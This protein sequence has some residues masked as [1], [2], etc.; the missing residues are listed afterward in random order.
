MERKEI[1]MCLS[2]RS[3][4]AVWLEGRSPCEFPPV[5]APLDPATIPPK[6]HPPIP[7]DRMGFQYLRPDNR[8]QQLEFPA[9]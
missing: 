6:S 3:V 8:Q 2:N 5:Q 7:Q 4:S 1:S 9:R